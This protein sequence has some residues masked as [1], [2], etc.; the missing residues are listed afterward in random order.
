[1]LTTLCCSRGINKGLLE[2]K[3]L[4]LFEPFVTFHGYGNSTDYSNISICFQFIR[5]IES[6]MVRRVVGKKARTT[7]RKYLQIILL[8]IR[9][10]TG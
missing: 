8:V 5:S 9:K 1:M 3:F 7:S 2:Y 10:I 4:S 6:C